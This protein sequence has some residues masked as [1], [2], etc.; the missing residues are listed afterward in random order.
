MFSVKKI[1]AA[2]ILSSSF[3]LNTFAVEGYFTQDA[4]IHKM[5]LTVYGN[6]FKDKLLE[7]VHHFDGHTYGAILNVPIN[8][9]NQIQVNYPFRTE[10]H[11][12]SSKAAFY[13]QH[14]RIHG[15]GGV[16]EFA[17]V[18]L[19]HKFTD[20]NNKDYSIIGFG[21]IGHR[22]NYLKND[23]NDRINHRGR[24][25]GGGV[26]AEKNFDSGIHALGNATLDY[27]NDTDDLIYSDNVNF[28]MGD[29]D[30]L[31]THNYLNLLSIL[32]PYV[33]FRAFADFQKYNTFYAEAGLFANIFNFDLLAGY[34]KGLNS[35]ADDNMI[36]F[37]IRLGADLV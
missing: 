34:I 11:A 6:E 32:Q 23:L 1:I 30:L 37:K 24:V 3:I 13:N 9:Y 10:G 8:N 15:A 19:D 16:F 17:T 21:Q 5:N 27:Y 22:S 28:F 25:I 26:R 2:S 33:E 14:I 18:K 36:G 7:E 31:L 35:K 20:H 29:F 12:D 4:Q